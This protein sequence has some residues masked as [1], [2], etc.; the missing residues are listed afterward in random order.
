M[1]DHFIA[2]MIGAVIITS[3]VG[4]VFVIPHG[5]ALMIV[6]SLLMLAYGLGMMVMAAYELNKSSK[7]IDEMKT[8]L[9]DL[10]NG[11]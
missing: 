3:V 2:L 6:I 1:K 7:R 10:A 8:E 4:F 11:R 9:K 5:E